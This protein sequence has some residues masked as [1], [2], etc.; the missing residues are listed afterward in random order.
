MKSS[1]EAV[2]EIKAYTP[3]Q[4]LSKKGDH[5]NAQ[6][7]GETQ[8]GVDEKDE[9]DGQLVTLDDQITDRVT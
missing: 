4:Q 6:K 8:Q 5:G 7:L 3:Y 9:L 1:Y 2:G